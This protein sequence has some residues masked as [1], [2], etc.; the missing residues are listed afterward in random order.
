M[1]AKR[2]AAELE[3]AL[4][5]INELETKIATYERRDDAWRSE[6]DQLKTERDKLKAD[7]E[8]FVT[9]NH[10]GHDRHL[11]AEGL[12]AD[13]RKQIERIGEA[14]WRGVEMYRTGAGV[15]GDL[16]PERAGLV[17]WLL[18]QLDSNREIMNAWETKLAD[19]LDLKPMASSTPWLLE[20]VG[21][22][23]QELSNLRASHLRI[24]KMHLAEIDRKL[25]AQGQLERFTS[26]CADQAIQIAELRTEISQLREDARK[27]VDAD[28]R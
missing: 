14:H 10:A 2:D 9:I 18:E 12:L 27:A 13:A 8:A 6:V 21:K 19:A 4:T 25:V 22:Q 24:E 16:P 11:R 5:R 20:Q 7:Y 1:I 15:A 17:V 23:R 26:T 28:G 3:R